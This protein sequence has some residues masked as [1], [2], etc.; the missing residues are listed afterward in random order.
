M[1]I[2]CNVLLVFTVLKEIF[3]L[4]LGRKSLV[5]CS[6][7][8]FFSQLCSYAPIFHTAAQSISQ[9]YRPENVW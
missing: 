6:Q 9:L 5:N 7:L 3:V 1:A 4:K 2:G 8:E